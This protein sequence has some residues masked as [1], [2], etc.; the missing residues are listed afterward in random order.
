[1]LNPNATKSAIHMHNRGFTLVEVM[2]G[3]AIFVIGFLAVSSMQITAINGNAGARGA[4]EAATWATDQLETLIALP[5]DSIVSGGPVINGA[6]TISW[7]VDADTPLPHTKTIVVTVDW[8]DR[9]AKDF[10]LTYMKTAN[11]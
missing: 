1:M 4:T 3:M 8:Q 2:I 11:M 7:E 5:Y 9:G 10:R 6:Y